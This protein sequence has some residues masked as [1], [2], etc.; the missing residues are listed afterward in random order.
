MRRV[1]NPNLPL[2]SV[3]TIVRNGKDTLPATIQAVVS[4][5]YPNIE[6]VIVDGASTDGTVEIIRSREDS[7]SCWV[8]EPDHGT[9]DAMNKAIS[10][11]RGEYVSWLASGD[12]FDPAF[13]ETAVSTLSSSGAD[14]VFGDLKTY[15]GDVLV[16]HVRGDQ[17]DPD[18]TTSEARLL[19]YPAMVT[20]TSPTIVIKRACFEQ[21]GLF[22][23]SYDVRNDFDWILRLH[24][25]GGRGVYDGR[26]IGHFRLGGVS[27][28]G[29][30]FAHI[31]E[32]LR[33][34]RRHG[35]LTARTASPYVYRLIRYSVGHVARWLLPEMIRRK[36]KRAAHLVLVQW[37]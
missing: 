26:L 22:D 6:Y 1:S 28:A 21:I 2:V 19:A 17:S 5:T 32:N 14:F 35:L 23:L 13:I 10:L 4:Q 11:A 12:W 24:R 15:K 27:D 25:S 20:R 33:I 7:I 29:S 8:S 9:S 31:F 18:A 34:L 37:R 3:L 36:V 16:Q 30:D